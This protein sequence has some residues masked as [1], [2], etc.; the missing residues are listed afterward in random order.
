MSGKEESV[1]YGVLSGYRIDKV[2]ETYKGG[3]YQCPDL[4]W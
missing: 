1:F 3:W 2:L 4:V